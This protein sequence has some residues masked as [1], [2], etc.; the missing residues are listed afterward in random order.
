MV[1]GVFWGFFCFLKS[2]KLFTIFY[3]QQQCVRVTVSLHINDS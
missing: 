3:P 1:G 2:A